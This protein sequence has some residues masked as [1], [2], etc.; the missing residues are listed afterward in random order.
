MTMTG[1]ARPQAANMVGRWL[2]L[3]QDEAVLVLRII[4]EAEDHRPANPTAW[5][6]AALRKRTTGPPRYGNS[7]VKEGFL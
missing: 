6:E 2:Q 1:K 4:D 3:A 7:R 5:I